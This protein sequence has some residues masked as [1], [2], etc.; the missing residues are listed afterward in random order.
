MVDT[1]Q[2]EIDLRLDT[3][4]CIERELNG[5]RTILSD[6]EKFTAMTDQQLLELMTKQLGKDCLRTLVF[7]VAPDIIKD[8]DE[9]LTAK[10]CDLKMFLQSK[11]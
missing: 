11:S 6:T 7:V 3:I 5:W 8:R 1:N 9:L 10:G 4:V 2:M